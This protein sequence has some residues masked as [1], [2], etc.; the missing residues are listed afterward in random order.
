MQKDIPIPMENFCK[1]KKW[2]ILLNEFFQN[3]EIENFNI[4]ILKSDAGR[5]EPLGGPHLARGPFKILFL[6]LRI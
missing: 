3:I 2:N 1:I 5:I 6:F 4:I